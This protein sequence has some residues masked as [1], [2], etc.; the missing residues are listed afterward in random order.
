MKIC[1]KV[2][3]LI[4]FT[5]SSIFGDGF[6]FAK[7]A[8]EFLSTGVGAR[9]LGMGGAFVALADDGT[10]GYWNPSGLV[11]L[12]YPQ[13]VLM[14]SERFKGEVNYDYVSFSLPY[15]K[16]RSLSFSLIRLGIDNIADTRNAWEDYGLDGI[17]N[18]GDYGENNGVLDPGELNVDK[19]TFFSN[20]DYAFFISY[21]KKEKESF[22]YGGNI[23]I[24][25]RSIGEDSAFG[26]G[27]DIGIILKKWKRLS[28]GANLMDATSTAIMWNTG[29]KELI[30]PTL[31]L[32]LAYKLKPHFFSGFIT[33]LIDWDVRFENR[34]FAS[35]YNVGPVSIDPHYGIELNV[36]SRVFLR[37]GYDDVKRIGFGAGV[38]LP[39]LN[40]DYSF[41]SFDN[42]D[43][44]GN[45]HIISITIT[46]EEEKF[47]R[48]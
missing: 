38:K 25:K 39:K 9:P 12:N 30:S 7:F 33:P 23:K 19:I 47:R 32:G 42:D 4:F 11:F 26:I 46:I 16:D 1:L 21:A 24:I 13:I 27:F 10:A 45:T 28:F 5:Y 34:K 41:N 17:P 29:R 40:V 20:T 48:K 15:R 3:A 14:H 44:L 35:Q 43:Q 6:E 18:T 2:I 36:K 8:G 31:K 22:T 37:G